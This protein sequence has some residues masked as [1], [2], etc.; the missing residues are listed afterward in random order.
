MAKKFS[1]DTPPTKGIPNTLD[2]P[3]I[4]DPESVDSM[5]VDMPELLTEYKRSWE[6]RTQ[7]T[8]DFILLDNLADGVPLVKE[9]GTPFVGDT[10]L[11]GLVRSI[12]RDSLKQLP[13]LSTTVNGSKNNIP[14]IICNYLNKKFAFNED[15]FGKGLLS[16]LQIGAEQ[17]LAHGYAPFLVATG[18]MYNDFG[19]TMRLLHYTD[20]CLEPGVSDAN[21]SGYYFVAAH[22]TQGRVK[23]ILKAAKANKKTSWNIKA[24]TELLKVTP[25]ATEYSRYESDPRRHQTGEN[26][27]LTY[28]IV[29]R[30]ET[31]PGAT[32]IT[33]TPDY[34]D[35][36]LRVIESKSKWG[37]PRV[38]YLVIDPAPLHPFGI[39]RVRLASPNA[40]MLNIYYGGTAAMLLINS[41]PPLLKKGT[42]LGKTDLKRG[43]VWATVDPQASIEMKNMDNGALEQFPTMQQQLSGQIQ[44]I[45]GGQ[46]PTASANPKL[47]GLGKTAPGVEAAQD[48][49]GVQS[50][51][52][53][54]I[55]ENFLR[56][57]AL[58]G[59]DTLLSESE[60]TDL[61]IVDDDTKNQINE[62][63]PNFI[64]SDNVFKM[65]WAKFY[66]SIKQWS[67]DV[68]VSLSP[69]Q[70]KDKK[71]ADL[72]DMLVVV[73]QNAADIPGAPQ[74]IQ[75]I[76]TLLMQDMTP[77]LSAG[78][79]PQGAGQPGG[80]PGAPGDGAGGPADAGPK[81]TET[82]DLVKLLSATTDP[83]VRNHIL[84]LIVPGAPMET[85]PSPNA[86][87]PA[88]PAPAA[89]P[90][91]PEPPEPP[92]DPAD[93][94]N[95][96]DAPADIQRQMEARK[97]FL[98][99]KLHPRV[100]S[101]LKTP[102]PPPPAPVAAPRKS[103]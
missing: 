70:M 75:Q 102:I 78:T 48:A 49:L 66:E 34:L 24:L 19:T 43:A 40:N 52:V 47:S 39:S 68:D 92:T 97:G 12:P 76:T 56:Q 77:L 29:T 6:H 33:F 59:L 90:E 94:L 87:A 62:I 67:V 82:A 80:A 14:A 61:L 16:T 28:E 60:G 85:A 36:P 83:A 64:G 13:V 32:N 99:S 98:P 7:Y 22:L 31:G 88:T 1:Q 18:L 21:E 41:N 57:Y 51:Q 69:D 46:T 26:I 10:T 37:Y 2:D 72:Q 4:L 30:Y 74:L 35:A 55:L 42:F 79:A 58:V 11:P 89:A 54:K 93:S 71:R 101:T 25:T 86:P 5:G 96:K 9:E 15:T 95:Y 8:R 65:D 45:M 73:A 38:Q 50:T 20:N 53:T 91:M 81:I 44:N 3:N 63:S 84:Q 103:K 23:K 100:A 17:S 27:G